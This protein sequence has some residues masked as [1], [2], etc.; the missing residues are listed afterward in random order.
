MPCDLMSSVCCPMQVVQA[1]I[2]GF[3][4]IALVVSRNQGNFKALVGLSAMCCE[5]FLSCAMNAKAKG[6]LWH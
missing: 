6:R 2:Q 1:G 4:F 5:Y 3:P